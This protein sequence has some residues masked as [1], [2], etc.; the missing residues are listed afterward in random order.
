MQKGVDRPGSDLPGS[1]FTL[2]AADP[3]LCWAACNTTADC[4]SWAYAIPAC[5]GFN[6][7]TCWLKNAFIPVQ[8]DTCR[9]SGE[10]GTP[11]RKFSKQ[12]NNSNSCSAQNLLITVINAHARPPNGSN[13]IIILGKERASNYS[14]SVR[15]CNPVHVEGKS[16]VRILLRDLT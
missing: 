7:P 11:Q 4:L 6:E 2:V 10:Q 16:K 1:P 13:L 3:A 9:D 12:K 8:Q 15:K 5:D 14:L